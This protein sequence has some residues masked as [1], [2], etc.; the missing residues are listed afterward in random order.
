VASAK[1]SINMEFD[2]ISSSSSP[3]LHRRLDEAAILIRKDRLV[4]SNDTQ[5]ILGTLRLWGSYFGFVFLLFCILRIK[6]K[7]IFNIRSWVPE[8]E[9]EIAKREYGLFNWIWKVYEVTEEEIFEQC[10][11]DALCYL[12]AM[13]FGRT[14]GLFGCFNAA[15][16]IPLYATAVASGETTYLQDHFVRISIANLPRSSPRFLGTV[17]A[18]YITFFY[19]MYLLVEE[20]K[21]YTFW[22]HKFLSRR[23]PS[24]YTVYVSG[25]PK[26]Y[27]TS[28]KLFTYFQCCS[29]DGVL[30]S[31]VTL[32]IPGLEA[33]QARRDT[34]IKYLEHTVALEKRTGHKHHHIAF[35][36][37][38]EKVQSVQEYESELN[39]LNK[40]IP[41]TIRAVIAVNDRMRSQ[42][43]R[44]EGSKS[45]RKGLG[46][47][48]NND[49]DDDDKEV[50]EMAGLSVED[51]ADY[52]V[53]SPQ[54][55]MEAIT[56]SD[57]E[58][59]AVFGLDELN[60]AFSNVG[61]DLEAGPISSEHQFE[62][63]EF[64]ATVKQDY[65]LYMNDPIDEEDDNCFEEV[66]NN[67]LRTLTEEN[68]LALSMSLSYTDEKKMARVNDV[69]VPRDTEDD[70]M[71]TDASNLSTRSSPSRSPRM[72]RFL[73]SR[74]GR[75][76]RSTSSSSSAHEVMRKSMVGVA[77][78]ATNSIIKGSK[79]ARKSIQKGGSAVVVGAR[80]AGSTIVS[81]SKLVGE[82][83]I[84]NVS[85]DNI[86][87]ES[88]RLGKT[89]QTVGKQIVTSAGSV[90][91]LLLTKYEGCPRN[92]GFVVFKNLYT[93]QAVLQ[94][95][96][97]P[98][99]HYMDVMPA[100]D[101]EDIFWPNVGLPRRSI[102]VGC[103]LSLFSTAVLCFFWSVP[104]AF[105]STLT[106]VNTLKSSLPRLRRFID[107][108][109][110]VEPLLAQAAPFLLLLCTEIF[111]PSLLKRFAKWEG[112]VSSAILEA[113][114]FSKLGCF[115]VSWK[116]QTSQLRITCA[117][118]NGLSR[119]YKL[120]LFL[121]YLA[122][123]HRCSQ[124]YWKTLKI[125]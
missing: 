50:D 78:K 43:N 32:D 79:I 116:N 124:T 95:V 62:R 112:H 11:M 84:K 22:R 68:I 49:G 30:E 82:T 88:A 120:S 2:E 25:I 47:V 108:H 13:R 5:L 87:D 102:E 27:R 123:L 26:M 7:R 94:M 73:P 38:L 86:K 4:T 52:A 70:A 24:N 106:E 109:P 113:S 31:H 60:Y 103:L 53:I 59:Q 66:V 56:K 37:G 91:P 100:P 54:N 101:P 6:F 28:F 114:V 122:V 34:V 35:R 76:L 15:W 12:R 29:R 40:L 67:R 115:M 19:T 58:D 83:I 23:S 80:E 96:H 64:I 65:S 89:A 121:Q 125:L 81:G 107:D 111:L 93:T 92:A 20:M 1:P 104:T 33:K 46:I 75:S 21:W 117:P 72:L 57:R 110:G 71:K 36:R 98:T 63:E 39:E 77:D 16:L 97:H 118:H 17:I 105:I 90:V 44:S 42:L 119:L 3:L 99:A 10:G 74:S 61:S 45:G 41:G 48:S 14:L 85:I 51:R 18:A 8:L 69:P 55:T 9:C